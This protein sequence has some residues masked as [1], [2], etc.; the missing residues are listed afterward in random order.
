M[1]QNT[2]PQILL[3]PLIGFNRTHQST[4]GMLFTV[5][6]EAFLSRH[7]ECHLRTLKNDGQ[8]DGRALQLTTLSDQICPGHQELSVRTMS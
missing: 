2:I 3:Q 5:S 1:W 7:H 4:R 8:G 6:S